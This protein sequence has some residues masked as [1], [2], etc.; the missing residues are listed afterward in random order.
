[1]LPRPQR[2]GG[3]RILIGGN[4]I[5]RTLPL[6]VRYADIW[7]GSFLP[8]EEFRKR[9]EILDGLLM[10]AG[11][12][13]EDV[14]RTLM[15]G[16]FFGRDLAEAGRRLHGRLEDPRYAG[17]SLKEVIDILASQDH[18]IVGTADMVIEQIKA[19]EV[20]GVEELM[21]QWFDIDDI[22]GLRAFARSVLPHV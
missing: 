13:P 21:L 5:K 9:S 17:K 22:D 16:L 1:M 7:N 2:P 10:Q 11:R 18:E 15:R 6:V 4:G 14:Q 20:V 12:K 3:P 8:P 19:Y